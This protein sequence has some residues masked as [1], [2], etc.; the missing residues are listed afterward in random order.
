MSSVRLLLQQK[1]SSA[2]FPLALF[3]ADTLIIMISMGPPMRFPTHRLLLKRLREQFVDVTNH[4]VLKNLWYQ[5]QISKEPGQLLQELGH[6]AALCLNSRFLCKLW[7][8][9]VYQDMQYRVNIGHW[10]CSPP[11]TAAKQEMRGTPTMRPSHHPPAA[12]GPSQL[13]PPTPSIPFFT[14]QGQA[15]ACNYITVIMYSN[16]VQWNL[17][18]II[19]FPRLVCKK[20]T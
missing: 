14:S 3:L 1:A 4:Q 12:A 17:I 6:H 8:S 10:G 2:Q 7:T 5:K 20:Y 13:T 11:L 16:N 19:F 9:A 18:H 15:Q